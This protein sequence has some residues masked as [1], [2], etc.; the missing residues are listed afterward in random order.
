MEWNSKSA[1]TDF[2]N[3]ESTITVLPPWWTMRDTAEVLFF[4][5][6]KRVVCAWRHPPCFLCPLA[7]SDIPL[8]NL[9]ATFSLKQ[10]TAI[11][12]SGVPY[13]LSIY[14]R[15]ACSTLILHIKEA[16][17]KFCNAAVFSRVQFFAVISRESIKYLLMFR[18]SVA[19]RRTLT[20]SCPT[21]IYFWFLSPTLSRSV[22]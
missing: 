15:R 20:S 11:I 12:L 21:Y 3:N 7:L 22:V 2:V 1:K 5:L 4:R 9:F 17:I 18:N 16:S 6:R 19:Y 13:I 10:Q 14:L 8:R